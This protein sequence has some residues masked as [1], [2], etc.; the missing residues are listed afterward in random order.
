VT[1]RAQPGGR[2]LTTAEASSRL[3]V[4]PATLYAY[5]SRGLLHSHRLGGG[6]ESRFE[7]SEVERLAARN[8]RGG[9]AGGLE[10]VVDSELTLL[11]PAGAF[12]YRGF[13]VTELCRVST[14][15]QVAEWLWTAT[16]P[17][18]PAVAPWPAPPEALEVARAAAA[19]PP[20]GARPVDRLIAAVAAIAPLDPLRHDR[21]PAAVAACTKAMLATLVDCLPDARDAGDAGDPGDHGVG[22]ASGAPRSIAARL[23]RKLS[24][25]PAEERHVAALDAALILLA[26]HELAASTLA[27]RVAAST[28]ADPYRVVLAGLGTLDGPLHGRASEE[29]VALLAEAEASGA[30]EAVGARLRRGDRIPGFGHKVYAG[31]DPRWGALFGLLGEA[32]P[33]SVQLADAEAV[34][35]LVTG[36]DGPYPNVDLAVGALQ[37][38]AGLVAGAG[39]TIFATARIAGWVAHA[40]EEYE[41]PLRFRPRAVYV[42]P[43]PGESDPQRGR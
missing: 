1:E 18:G 43:A 33:A 13:D 25:G 21:R 38:A 36:R 14:F 29:V 15:E 7:A 4:Q 42:G 23:W 19:L 34:S 28:R 41:H 6:R 8:R 31:P 32:W 3:G 11:D 16:Y 10:L 30:A 27:A 37:R 12:F 26:D 20:A 24:A 35:R 9:R 39:E 22:A 5:V 40:I 17:L 2:L